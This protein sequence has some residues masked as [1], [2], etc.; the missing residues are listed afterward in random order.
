MQP[1]NIHHP[2]TDLARRVAA[3]IGIGA[4]AG[5]VSAS[6]KVS[7]ALSQITEGDG[8][9][10][11]TRKI[12]VLVADGVD[13][14]GTRTLVEGLRS[15][16]AAPVVLAITDGTVQTADGGELAVDG[17]INTVASVLF[18]AVAVPCGPESVQTLAGDGYAVHFVAEAYKH[19]KPVAAFGSGI[20]LLRKSGVSQ[21]FASGASTTSD[22]GVVTTT[23]AG[24]NLGDEFVT[25]FASEISRHRAWERITDIVPA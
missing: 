8:F 14:T 10:I 1:Q 21:H 9:G 18:D 25:A 5:Q 17:A 24:Q 12:A 16:G 7:P 23:A 22:Q 3:G 15:R 11:T 6:S 2:N 20:D 13:A 19:A 4:P